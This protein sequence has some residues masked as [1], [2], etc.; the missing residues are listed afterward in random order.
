MVIDIHTHI[1]ADA[2]AA[3]AVH[4]LE[5]KGDIKAFLPGTKAGLVESM[6]RA[7]ISVSV[8]QPVVTKPSQTETINRWAAEIRDQRI[9][10]FAGLH[11]DDQDYKEHLRQ[12]KEMGFPGVK[13]HPDYQGFFVDEPRMFPIY[14]EI[15]KNG[16]ILLFHA[17]LDIG[18]PPPYHGTP[19]RIAKVLDAVPGGTVI[20]AHLGGHAMW[21]QVERHLAGR[22][23]YLDT[24]MGI[25]YYGGSRLVKIAR[26][27]GT[28][29]IL[30]GTDSPWT[31]Q[32]DE[33]ERMRSLP[34][35][36]AELNGILYQNAKKL[37]RL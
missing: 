11:P 26:M 15:F 14:E 27:H 7:G 33:L 34:F 5:E 20:A 36:P 30:F 12:I 3:R 37:L 29:K 18:F 22:N 8:I 13:L 21:D 9:L 6:D 10:P 19:E 35:T 31:S 28:D 25:E 23:L 1:F 24:S 32:P 16:L 17:G 4:R 2:L